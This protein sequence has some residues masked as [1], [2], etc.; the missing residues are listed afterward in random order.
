MLGAVDL[1]RQALSLA[2]P[3]E[4]GKAARSAGKRMDEYFHLESRLEAALT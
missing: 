1:Q 4:A 3:N 2:D